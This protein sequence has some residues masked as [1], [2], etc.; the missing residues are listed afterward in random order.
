MDDL[1]AVLVIAFFYS[2]SLHWD[3]LYYGF[4]ILLLLYIASY[5]KA[6]NNYIF[7]LSGCVIWVLFLKSGVHPTIAGI[8]M[9]F[10][11]P[12]SRKVNLKL[13]LE[14]LL[15]SAEI[16]KSTDTRRA[17]LN[18][19]ELNAIDAI[20]DMT[21]EMQSPLQHLEN[22]LHGWVIY[23]IMPIF[24][25]A[26]A[27]VVLSGNVSFTDP[28]VWH[29]TFSMVVGKLVG[30][31]VFTYAA[32]RFGLARLPER[33]TNLQLIGVSLLGGLGFTMALFIAQLAYGSGELLASAKLGILTGSLIAGIGGFLI[34]RYDLNKNPVW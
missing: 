26:N 9:A 20:E 24:A 25:L 18:N 34:L 7:L 5:F 4:G 8:L 33:M 12:I 31:S 21:T 10:T 3:Y 23:V 6:Y 29:I 30:I 2:E 15:A 19:T 13:H 27:G 22:R 32:V 11:I 16:F 17:L 1:A 14:T 28:L